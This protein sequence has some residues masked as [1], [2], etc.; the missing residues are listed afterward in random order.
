MKKYKE[1]SVKMEAFINSA[2]FR[3][4]W[5]KSDDL[6]LYSGGTRLE[7][8]PDR[9]SFLY[10]SLPRGKFWDSISK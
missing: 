5:S 7:S 10:F 8:R 1:V 6:D 4:G 3:T 2:L 9:G